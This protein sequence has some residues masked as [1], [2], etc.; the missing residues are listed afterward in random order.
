MKSEFTHARAATQMPAVFVLSFTGCPTFV[1]PVSLMVEDTSSRSSMLVNSNDAANRMLWGL[2]N[3]I[4]CGPSRE[5]HASSDGATFGFFTGANV[6]G[7][8]GRDSRHGF[9]N[10]LAWNGITRDQR[11]A[12]SEVETVQLLGQGLSALGLWRR[13]S[14]RL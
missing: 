5:T 11:E 12:V 1:H 2:H 8:H 6:V 7:S 13:L 3:T 14:Q 10:D 9:H 4:V